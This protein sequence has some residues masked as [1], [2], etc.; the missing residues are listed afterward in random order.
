MNKRLH[1]SKNEFIIL[2]DIV[3]GELRML[4]NEYDDDTG[5][6]PGK[7]RVNTLPI[8]TDWHKRFTEM[9]DKA[10]AVVHIREKKVGALLIPEKFRECEMDMSDKEIAVIIQLLEK[11]LKGY[12]E[13]LKTY[14]NEQMSKD[15]QTACSLLTRLRNT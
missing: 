9:Q 12:Q 10:G 1:L 8:L 4:I 14:K 11:R 5:R 6:Q 2:E 7:R 13:F 3:G 15:Y